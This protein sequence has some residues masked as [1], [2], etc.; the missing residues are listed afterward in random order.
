MATGDVRGPEG[1]SVAYDEAIGEMQA[2]FGVDRDQIDESGL[3]SAYEEVTGGTDPGRELLTFVRSRRATPA[4][5]VGGFESY[6]FALSYAQIARGLQ[7]EANSATDLQEKAFLERAARH[8]RSISIVLADGQLER[9]AVDIL[10]GIRN[11]LRKVETRS[12]GIHLLNLAA[13]H[14][15]DDIAY[16]KALENFIGILWEGFHAVDWQGTVESV[17]ERMMGKYEFIHNTDLLFTTDAAWDVNTPITSPRQWSPSIWHEIHFSTHMEKGITIRSLFTLLLNGEVNLFESFRS[18]SWRYKEEGDEG[19]LQR[20]A[21]NHLML[22]AASQKLSDAR[23]YIVEMTIKIIDSEEFRNEISYRQSLREIVDDIIYFLS[24]PE[25]NPKIEQ[26]TAVLTGFVYGMRG[27]ESRYYE[28]GNALFLLR[29]LIDQSYRQNVGTAASLEELAT[30]YARERSGDGPGGVSGTPPAAAEA[31][32]TSAPSA[33][34]EGSAASAASAEEIT[35]DPN[36]V[37]FDEETGEIDG[38]TGDEEINID[39]DDSWA[40]GTAIYTDGAIATTVF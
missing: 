40:W 1:Y 34:P 19:R 12:A 15:P 37:Y 30:N 36:D 2:R 9:T 31:S 7:D 5:I 14:G 33:P 18:L 32:G 17:F 22:V 8:A 27:S 25:E 20:R 38:N 21:L 3:M 29:P 11:N 39:P 35:A 16:A 28:F 26:E 6:L 24:Q 23:R 13:E 10:I 4:N